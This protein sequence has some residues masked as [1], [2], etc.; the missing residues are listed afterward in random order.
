MGCL[1]QCSKQKQQQEQQQQQQQEQLFS[2][3]CKLHMHALPKL[4]QPA[5]TYGNR[6]FHLSLPPTHLSYHLHLSLPTD[7][8]GAM[9]AAAPAPSRRVALLVRAT[10]APAKP[11]VAPSSK[12]DTSLTPKAQGFTMPGE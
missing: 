11:Q 2:T 7:P 9:R 6:T 4:Y 12:V 3:T 5:A 1:A 10:A 8:A